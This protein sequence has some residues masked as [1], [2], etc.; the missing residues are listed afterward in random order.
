MKI[1]ISCV[2]SF[3]TLFVLL[4][5]TTSQV[6]STV[7]H[8]FYLI[9]GAS[10]NDLGESMKTRRPHDHNAYTKW[11]IDWNYSFRIEP[12]QWTL[13]KFDTRVQIRYTFP[14]WQTTDTPDKN[15]V[16]E[17][18]RFMNAVTE[19]EIGHSDL[20]LA[21]AAEM[22][23][24]MSFS[25]WQGETR[26]EVK[27]RIDAKC[28]EILEKYRKLEIEYDKNTDHGKTQGARLSMGTSK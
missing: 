24:T 11:H 16:T 22:N 4:R 17:W 9:E 18:E 23:R 6:P 26:R 7:R 10:L 27:E 13:D 19:H 28:S 8:D 21:A 25:V 3:L 1:Q 20:G 5:D 2:L 14:K 15:V 12:N